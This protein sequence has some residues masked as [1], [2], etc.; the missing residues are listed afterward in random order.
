LE[1]NVEL[2]SAYVRADFPDIQESEFDELARSLAESISRIGRDFSARVKAKD[3]FE[4]IYD[5][6]QGSLVN[7]ARIFGALMATYVFISQY[8]NFRNGVIQ[9]YE[10]ARAAGES[11]VSRI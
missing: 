4:L 10:D 7:V 8:P 11:I 2:V 9:I 6:D 5:L 1:V 3:E